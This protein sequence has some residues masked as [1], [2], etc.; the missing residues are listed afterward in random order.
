MYRTMNTKNLVVQLVFRLD[1]YVQSGLC[2]VKA[3]AGENVLIAT[4]AIKK[5]LGRAWGGVRG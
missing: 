2:T 1:R 5:I 3:N 4:K